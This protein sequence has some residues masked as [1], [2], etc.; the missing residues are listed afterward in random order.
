M[1]GNSYQKNGGVGVYHEVPNGDSMG[2][3]GGKKK[4]II[5]AVVAVAVAIGAYV[6]FAR[7]PAGSSVEKVMEKTSLKV[8]ADGSMKLFDDQSTLF[9]SIGANAFA[10]V[11]FGWNNESRESLLSSR[12]EFYQ[13]GSC[14]HRR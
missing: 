3:S 11:F 13:L 10:G 9:L 5:G 4:L 14:Q 12:F 8:K 1:S 2:G 6:G 7:N